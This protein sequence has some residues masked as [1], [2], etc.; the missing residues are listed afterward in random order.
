MLILVYVRG[1]QNNLSTG[2][3]EGEVGINYQLCVLLYM[4]RGPERGSAI[5]CLNVSS[6]MDPL[7]PDIKTRS[8]Q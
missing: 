8:R 3:Q 7:K 2:P 1:R 4:Y 5:F 6:K